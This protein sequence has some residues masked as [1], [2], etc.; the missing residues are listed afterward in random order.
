[1]QE[2]RLAQD[3]YL[4]SKIS[5]RLTEESYLTSPPEVITLTKANLPKG[6]H[7]GIAASFKANFDSVEVDMSQRG[8][9]KGLVAGVITADAIVVK[10]LKAVLLTGVTY[11][12]EIALACR[13][14]VASILCSRDITGE[15]LLNKLES[16][17]TKSYYTKA[18]LDAVKGVLQ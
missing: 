9:I 15:L 18:L 2:S 10:I 6:F 11:N 13:D 16:M 17:E 12:S 14:M 4:T 5:E 7:T 3:F 8:E 1:M